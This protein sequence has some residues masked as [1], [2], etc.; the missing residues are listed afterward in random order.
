MAGE[1]IVQGENLGAWISAQKAGWEQLAPTQ[2]FLLETFWIGR[3]PA[4]EPAV[5]GRRSQ[6]ERWMVN[7]AAAHQ[8][9]PCPRWW[10][11]PRGR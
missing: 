11:T 9:H 7:L 3:A 2:R 6:D 10:H 1:L 5:P 8:Y 4:G